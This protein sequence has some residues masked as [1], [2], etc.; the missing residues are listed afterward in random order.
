MSDVDKRVKGVKVFQ[1]QR[2]KPF[3]DEAKAIK[4]HR[5]KKTP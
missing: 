2:K 5:R 3:T 1:G 4:E